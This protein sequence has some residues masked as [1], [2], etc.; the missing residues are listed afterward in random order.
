MGGALQTPTE[1][2]SGVPVLD[3][4]ALVPFWWLFASVFGSFPAHGF[5]RWFSSFD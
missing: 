4:N 2:V 1:R 3:K 5:C